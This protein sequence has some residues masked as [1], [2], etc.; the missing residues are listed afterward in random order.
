MKC[1]DDELIQ[2][3]IDG[4]VSLQ[5]TGHIEAHM[6]DCPQCAR[7]ID[8][9][10]AFAGYIKRDI[11]RLGGQPAVVPRFVA[12]VARKHRM[13]IRIKHYIYAASAACILVLII[14]TLP[15]NSREKE[16]QLIYSFE[17]DYDANRPVSQQEMVIKIIDPKGKVTEYN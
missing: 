13:N 9:Q 11:S 12:P 14:F 3:Y 1:I 15:K 4:E 8:E 2:K 7:N 17:G 16:I 6:A 5:E 10:S